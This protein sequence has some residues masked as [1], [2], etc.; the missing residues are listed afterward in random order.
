M[1][2][3]LQERRT[4]LDWLVEG[5]LEKN[6]LSH[7]LLTSTIQPLKELSVFVFGKMVARF[8]DIWVIVIWELVG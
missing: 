3:K 6:Y 5:F 2:K 4:F 7:Y 1:N 8:K